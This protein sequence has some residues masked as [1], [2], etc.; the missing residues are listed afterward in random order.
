MFPSLEEKPPYS[1]CQ[2]TVRPRP[3]IQWQKWTDEIDAGT[4]SNGCPRTDY[5]VEKKIPLVRFEER[6]LYLAGIWET[7]VLASLKHWKQAQL[8]VGAYQNPLP[9]LVVNGNVGSGVYY[10]GSP[11]CQK[12]HLKRGLIVESSEKLGQ[13]FALDYARF[14]AQLGAQTNQW[15]TRHD[16]HVAAKRAEANWVYVSNIPQYI[17]Q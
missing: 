1:W 6:A 5:R 16:W 14:K 2:I 13:C 17:S 4:S 10:T 7:D 11:G 12:V 3:Q 8:L 15:T 9:K